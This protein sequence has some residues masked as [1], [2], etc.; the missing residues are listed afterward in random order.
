MIGVA[1]GL[2]ATAPARAVLILAK[3]EALMGGPGSGD[4]TRWQSRKTTVEESLSLSV[5]DFR[6][7]LYH[8]CTGSFT[9]TYPTG[10]KASISYFVMRPGGGVPTVTLLYRWRSSEEIELPVRLQSTPAQFGGKRWWFTCPLVVRGV[11]CNRRVGKLYCPPGA[12]Y[13]GCRTCHELT[14]KSSQEAHQGERA[15]VKLGLT[16]EHARLFVK[17]WRV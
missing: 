12:K 1:A 14:Y 4:W 7:R 3:S 5:R 9:W 15:F 16:T 13:F 10:G 11:V 8:N 17:R 2:P 6:A